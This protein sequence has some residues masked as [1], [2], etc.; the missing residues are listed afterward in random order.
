M[1]ATIK[2]RKRVKHT[3]FP[4]G[5]G[6]V[7]WLGENRRRPYCARKTKGF[8]DKGHPIYMVIGY[9]ETFDEAFYALCE[10]NKN[11]YNL[12]DKDITFGEAA[13]KW[14][15]EYK[16][17]PPHGK[18]PSENTITYYEGRLKNC[19][20]LRN[21]KLKDLS[22]SAMQNFI[23]EQKPG[24]QRHLITVC[25]QIFNWAIKNEI[26]ERN[27]MQFVHKTA[28]TETKRNPFTA[29]EVRSIWNMSDSPIRTMALILLYTGMRVGELYTVSEVH[30]NYIRAGE[31]TEAGINRIIPLHSKIRQFADTLRE[32]PVYA[33]R[34]TISRLFSESFP[35]HTPHDCRRTFISRCVECGVDGTVARKITGH[36][37]KDIHETAY[38]FLNDPDFLCREVEKIEY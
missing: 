9:Y 6:S 32:P 2:K 27:P 22:V 36:V 13:D 10:Y 23:G 34:T 18:E 29:E 26:L 17:F 5:F 30:E 12:S 31:K 16:M 8:N 11:P 28:T 37:G 33:N 1:K 20:S 4:N 19:E 3:R 7:S 14:F 24:T 21:V 38:T 25:N 15:A 35:G